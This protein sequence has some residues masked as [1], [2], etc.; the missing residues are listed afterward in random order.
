MKALVTL[1]CPKR[2]H[3]GVVVVV[4][5]KPHVLFKRRH[6]VQ[7]SAERARA[8]Q[9]FTGPIPLDSPGPQVVGCR[10]FVDEPLWPHVQAL[11]A[12]VTSVRRG[13]TRPENAVYV[14]RATH[15][16]L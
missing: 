10:H 1:R 16:T 14:V 15:Q 2:C 12:L 8:G 9:D 13:D 5:N 11:Q 3:L 6:L 7:L 4:D